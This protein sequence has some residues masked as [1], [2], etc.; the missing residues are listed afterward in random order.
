MKYKINLLPE[1]E[2]SFTDKVIYFAFN[3]LRYILVI[4]QLVVIGVFFY[5]LQIDQRVI[6]LRESVDQKKEII[7]IVLPLLKE[8]SRVDKKGKEIAKIIKDQENFKSMSDYIFSIIPESI[9]LNSFDFKNNVLTLVG[10]SAD[11]KQIQMFINFLKTE[12]KF[13]NI[14]LKN[15]KKTETSY[16]FTISLE[17]YLS[18]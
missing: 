6:D 7:N 14:E 4:T 1:K 13:K 10:S 8:A 18:I 3:Y 11:P 9:V 15:L 17:K 16:I 12:K 5:R 2:K